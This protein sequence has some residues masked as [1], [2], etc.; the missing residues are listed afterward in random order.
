MDRFLKQIAFGLI[1]LSI[2]EITV[3]TAGVLTLSPTIALS[4]N[5]PSQ[6]DVLSEAEKSV[7]RIDVGGTIVNDN[8]IY[9]NSGT[10]FAITAEGAV[11]TAAHVV[12][13]STQVS[14]ISINGYINGDESHPIELRLER[15]DRG[16]DVAILRI[17]HQKDYLRPL[18]I[19]SASDG[20]QNVTVLGYTAGG[21]YLHS[22][23]VRIQYK[24]GTR[25]TFEGGT[26]Q[27]QSGGPLIDRFG[28]V[29]G[30]DINRVEMRNGVSLVGVN[31]AVDSLKFPI[32]DEYNVNNIED[33]FVLYEEEGESQ[34]YDSMS[35]NDV[36]KMVEKIALRNDCDFGFPVGWTGSRD[37]NEISI[38]PPE[39]FYLAGG[40]FKYSIV[41]SQ[42]TEED[43]KRR[44]GDAEPEENLGD[45]SLK[46]NESYV[47][48]NEKLVMEDG[49]DESI[50]LYK[51]IRREDGAMR[52]EFNQESLVGIYNEEP[53]RIFKHVCESKIG[54]PSDY[55]SGICTL[56]I[57]KSSTTDDVDSL[58]CKAISSSW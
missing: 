49:S 47:L 30:M 55:F 38:M 21:M 36:K 8:T 43:V 17:V 35:S 31:T 46:Q 9:N 58:T 22:T 4:Y 2:F 25:L 53:N 52:L 54:M 41:K 3:L 51:I 12:P 14:D 42:E 50:S 57:E 33:L 27:G 29:V 39:D 23:T 19:G 40:E 5:K 56:L 34:D 48:I 32:P 18:P 13:S 7:I 20:F 44:L 26:N 11:L 24:S 45:F 6:D 16:L 10:G 15:L 28:R 37:G 1:N